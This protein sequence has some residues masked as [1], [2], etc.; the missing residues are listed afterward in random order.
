MPGMLIQS[1]AGRTFGRHLNDVRG[2]CERH[3]V[4]ST[5]FTYKATEGSDPQICIEFLLDAE[6]DAFAQAFPGAERF[7]GCPDLD[8]NA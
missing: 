2:W 5:K 7:S 1:Q 4:E 3:K 6:A 8:F